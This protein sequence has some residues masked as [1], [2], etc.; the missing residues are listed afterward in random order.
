MQ[1]YSTKYR[2]GDILRLLPSWKFITD[3]Y[4]W[5]TMKCRY[6]V[7]SLVRVELNSNIVGRSDFDS[8]IVP[9]STNE[10]Y[11]YT[12]ESCVELVFPSRFF[13]VK[14]CLDFKKSYVYTLDTF[15]LDIYNNK[16]P[17]D[18]DKIFATYQSSNN[19]CLNR[20]NLVIS[21]LLLD[22]QIIRF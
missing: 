3:R 20:S 14:D 10:Q 4:N 5:N 6:P 11:N 7:N 12:L 21:K 9:I 13:V 22:K 15:D 19:L 16:V 8:P 1:R 2:K 18:I 17:L